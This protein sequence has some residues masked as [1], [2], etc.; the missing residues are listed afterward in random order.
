MIARGLLIIALLLSGPLSAH[1][2]KVGVSF[3]IPPYVIQEQGRGIELDLLRAAFDG[4]EYRLDFQY[5]PLERTFRMLADGKLDAIINVRP[6]ML[7]GAFLSRPVIRFRNQVFTLPP[8]TLMSLDDLATMRVTAFQRATRV[9]GPDF[10][11]VAARNPH[12]E[13]VAKQQTQVRQ[14]LLG[15]VDAVIME[16]RVFHY[17]LDQLQPA[18]PLHGS[19]AQI[20]AHSL[21]APTLYHFAFRSAA[22]RDHFDRALLAMRVDGRYEQIF[23]DYDVS[24]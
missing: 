8:F 9:L 14:L 12:Y 10:A 18:D 24:P 11:A 22:V 19:R 13:E 5:L 1:P 3:A 15:R 23:A 16:E 4:S 17:F 2:L 7:D 21:F 20:L 6:G